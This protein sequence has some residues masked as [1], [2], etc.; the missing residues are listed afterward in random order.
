V[1]ISSV[2]ALGRKLL[3]LAKL[4]NVTLNLHHKHNTFIP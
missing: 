3:C 4:P 2:S 1:I